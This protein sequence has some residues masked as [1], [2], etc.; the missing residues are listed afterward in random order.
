MSLNNIKIVTK[1]GADP[2]RRSSIIA[3]GTFDGVHV[4]H[5]SLLEKTGAMAKMHGCLAGAW[6]FAQSPAASLGLDPTPSLTTV[7]EK[8]ALMLDTGID[9]VAIGNF[10]AFR[11]MSAEDFID[12]VLKAQ[13]GAV[14]A[15]CGF[16]HR[17][18]SGG[19]GTPSL[20]YTHFGNDMLT[21]IPEMRVDGETVSS[22]TIRRLIMNGDVGMAERMLGRPFSLTSPVLE[23]KRLGRRLGFPTVNQIFGVG[24]VTPKNGIYAT[25]CHIDGKEY[26][27]VSNV[28]VRPTITDGSDSHALN[29]ETYIIGFS[30]E[31]YGKL[32]TVEFHSYLRGEKQFG[33]TDELRDAIAKDKENAIEYFTLRKITQ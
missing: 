30:G 12:N 15:V 28:G 26:V 13:L 2:A 18:G 9:F 8:V 1:N 17:F 6:C 23:G 22:S 25:L 27:G 21:V 33:S 5:R 29:C 16:N 14:G 10:D 20:L 24:C 31:L 7:D 32:L 19:L 4:A 11:E 3:L